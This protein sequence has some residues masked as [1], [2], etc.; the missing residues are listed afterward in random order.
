MTFQLTNAQGVRYSHIM[1]LK[2][3]GHLP[4]KTDSTGPRFLARLEVSK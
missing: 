2:P 1:Q 3:I 4:A